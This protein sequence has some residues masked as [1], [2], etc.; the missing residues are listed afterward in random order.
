MIKPFSSY[1]GFL[2]RVLF[3]MIPNQAGFSAISYIA[4]SEYLF[5]YREDYFKILSS[6]QVTGGYISIIKY[7]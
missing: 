2:G 3:T 5:E 7:S 1:N 6:T 4:F